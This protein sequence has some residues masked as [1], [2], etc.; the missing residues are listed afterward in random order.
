[1]SQLQMF[2]LMY[3]MLIQ[4][5]IVSSEEFPDEMEFTTTIGTERD[6]VK[7]NKF[8]IIGGGSGTFLILVI[9]CSLF[10]CSHYRR[11][12]EEMYREKSRQE[13]KESMYGEVM[14]DTLVI[15]G[16]ESDD[17]VFACDETAP[18]NSFDDDDVDF[19]E[20]THFNTSNGDIG[21]AVTV[22]EDGEESV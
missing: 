17:D 2:V 21:V 11:R 20:T 18:F 7:D 1:M 22:V 12:R 15:G 6:F 13:A 4:Y 16:S 5:L 10:C 3:L 14:A 19:D 8:I 9:F